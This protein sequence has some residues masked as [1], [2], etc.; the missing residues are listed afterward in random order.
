[1][2][3]STSEAKMGIEQQPQEATAVKLKALAGEA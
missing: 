2:G 3:L 1:M